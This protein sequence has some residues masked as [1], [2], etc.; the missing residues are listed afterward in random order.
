M[1]TFDSIY[2][3]EYIYSMAKSKKLNKIK[4]ILEAKGLT[5][6]WLA[7][8]AKITFSSVNQY[9]HG[10]REPSLETLFKLAKTLKVNPCELIN[11]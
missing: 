5:Q 3:N 4:E 10:K 2:T 9:Y 7:T 11:S 8:E 1:Y 6:Q